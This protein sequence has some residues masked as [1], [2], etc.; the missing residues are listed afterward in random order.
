[1]IAAA[2]K[3]EVK[4]TAIFK[5]LIGAINWISLIDPF[6]YFCRLK[7]KKWLVN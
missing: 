2:S 6:A 7:L 4:M 3:A 1:V 5:E